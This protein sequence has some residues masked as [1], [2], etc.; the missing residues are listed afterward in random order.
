[1]WWQPIRGHTPYSHSWST[2][3]IYRFFNIL[4]EQTWLS[5]F[6][7]FNYRYAKSLLAKYCPHWHVTWPA[8][9]DMGCR[10]LGPWSR[11]FSAILVS[12]CRDFLPTRFSVNTFIIINDP[13][14]IFSHIKTQHEPPINLIYIYDFLSKYFHHKEMEVGWQ[15]SCFCLPTVLG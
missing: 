14:N 13:L 3:Y 5:V 9:C 11:H 12:P 1:M 6:K 10:I 4:S 7:H 8:S 2:K 15:G